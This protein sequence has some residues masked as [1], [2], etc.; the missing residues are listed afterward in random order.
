MVFPPVIIFF[1]FYICGQ[2]KYLFSQTPTLILT[3][4]QI[5]TF[6]GHHSGRIAPYSSHLQATGGPGRTA[7][8]DNRHKQLAKSLEN[9]R[10]IDTPCPSPPPAADTTRRSNG[11]G[12]PAPPLGLKVEGANG[13]ATYR[14]GGWEVNPWSHSSRHDHS[15]ALRSPGP[16]RPRPRLNR[17]GTAYSLISVLF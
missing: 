15:Q 13:G 8:T 16:F 14:R 10:H 1:L 4:T 7:A 5:R 9:L 2:I 6:L 12:P 11:S 17:S 3:P